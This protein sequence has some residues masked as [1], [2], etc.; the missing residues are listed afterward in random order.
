VLS[1]VVALVV[2]VGV[3]FATMK[4]SNTPFHNDDVATSIYSLSFSPNQKNADPMKGD[5]PSLEDIERDLRVVKTVTN[6]VRTYSVSD[7]FDQVPEVADRLGMHVSLGVWAGKDEERTRREIEL[8]VALAK[9]HKSIDEIYIGNESI[10]RAEATPEQI[11]DLMREV[12]KRT[13]KLVTTGEPYHVWLE[14]PQLVK[15]ADFISAHIL[16][17]WEGV[18]AEAA[19]DFAKE[20]IAA[21]KDAYPHKRLVIGEFGWPSNKFNY[22]DAVASPA[23]QAR[24]VRSFIEYANDLDLEYNIIEAFDQPWKTQ[25]G[26]VGPYW[27]VFNADRQLKF[28]LEGD[29]QANPLWKKKAQVGIGFGIVLS[30]AFLFRR[31]STFMQNLAIASASQMIGWAVVAAAFVPVETYVNVGIVGMWVCSAPLILLLVATA[32]DRVREMAD[33]LFGWRPVRLIVPGR[34]DP[35]YVPKVSIHVP[36]CGEPAEMVAVT[37]ESMARLDYPNFEVLA[38]INN[39]TRPEL[40]E[41]IRD[42]CAQLGDR[43]KFVHLPKVSGF[44]A[45]ALNRALDYTAPDAEIIACVDADYVVDADWLKDLVP[46]FKDPKVALVQAPQE[47]RDEDESWFKAAMNAEY[48][49]FFDIGMVQ[50]NED[51]AI[52]AHGTMIMLR[53]SAMHEVGDWSEWCITEDTELGLRLFEA[54]YSAVYTTKRYGRGLLPDTLRAYRRQRDRWAYGAMRIMLHH[55]QHMMPWSQKLT[56]A[57]K[58]HFLT[59]W[60]HWIGDAAAVTLAVAN[61]GWVAFMQITKLGEPPN[62][63]LTAATSTAAAMTLFHMFALYAARVR[64]GGKHA[65]L[66]SLA[67]V[68]LQLTVAKAVFTGLVLANLP[69]NV[70]AK[71]GKTATGFRLFLQ[72]FGQE[73]VLA[74]LLIA[75]SAITWINNPMQIWEL[76]AF[77]VVLAIQSLPFTIAFAMGAAELVANTQ[78]RR[79]LAKS[80]VQQVP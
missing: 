59:G 17:Y 74:A 27:G 22:L 33:V 20:Q 48:A 71:G 53:R 41:P 28:P 49:G 61:L 3:H 62:A 26:D 66:A 54:G 52:I 36:A 72:T 64:R 16:P 19:L 21:L 77:A 23:N 15:G 43:F 55:F 35:D 60:L 10:L 31:R 58:Y 13:R 70:T 18:K 32:F 12:K 42:L 1:A 78:K 73:G 38:V 50:R 24:V 69:F 67:G 29:V 2:T 76:Y 30:L 11:V 75:A 51:D 68:S 14:N 47:H 39:T 44:K 4:V 56:G 6:R 57:Q 63:I 65:V 7:G 25:E 80:L 45:G 79:R 8:A 34:P 37:L 46:A 40:V 9:A 5:K